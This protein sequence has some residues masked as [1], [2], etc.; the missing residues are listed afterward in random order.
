M[1][2]SVNHFSHTLENIIEH[3]FLGQ[4]GRCLWLQGIKDFEILR[5]D[6]DDHGHDV[7]VEANGVMRHIQLKAMYDK[8]R[9]RDVNVHVKLLQKPSAC[10]IWLIYDPATLEISNFRWFGGEPGQPLPDIGDR[11]VKHSRANAQG[12]KAVRPNLRNVPQSWF[13]ITDNIEELAKWLFGD[14]GV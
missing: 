5:G 4:L 12:I 2:V 6:T 10:V 11:A 1:D 3:E 8:G 9:R 7:I 13:D 14:V